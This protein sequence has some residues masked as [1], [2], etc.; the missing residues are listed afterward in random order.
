[1]PVDAMYLMTESNVA[2]YANITSHLRLKFQPFL[3][4]FKN[5][6]FETNQRKSPAEVYLEPCKTFNLL[7]ANPTK[8]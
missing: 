2:N 7:S 4:G 3:N 6:C 1:M 8:W 5:R